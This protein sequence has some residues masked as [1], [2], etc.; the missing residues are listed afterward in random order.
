MKVKKLIIS[1]ND[2]QK[3]G[4]SET[5][6][7]IKSGIVGL[8]GKNGSGKTRILNIVE[9]FVGS[10]KDYKKKSN[11]YLYLTGAI[12]DFD[13]AMLWSNLENY[14]IRIDN[15]LLQS[16]DLVMD[17]AGTVTF[18]QLY[19][20]DSLPY[21]NILKTF[22]SKAYSWIIDTFMDGV[23]SFDENEDD[24]SR[25]R[26]KLFKSLLS[27]FIGKDIRLRLSKEKRHYLELDGVEFKFNLLSPGEKILFYYCL[28]LFIIQETKNI[29][30]KDCIIIIDE[31]ELHLH[32]DAQIKL[33][34]ALRDIIGDSGQ[35]WIASHSLSILS[36]LNYDEIFLVKNNKIICP[37]REIPKQS[38]LE[39]MG[40]EGHIDRMSEF[41]QSITS[42][43]YT[44]FMAQCFINP[45]SI[46]LVD[47]NDPQVEVFMNSIKEKNEFHILDFG[48]GKGRVISYLNDN[49]PN[50]KSILYSAMDNDPKSI[51][52]LKKIK[53][54]TKIYNN[55]DNLG[56][57]N[58][59][60]VLMCNVLHE[61]SPLYWYEEFKKIFMSIKD[62]GFLIIIEDEVIPKGERPNEIGFL[63][64]DQNELKVLFNMS[65]L[66]SL[67]KPKNE[68]WK[69][70]ILC[71]LI[72]KKNIDAITPNSIIMAIELLKDRAYKHV[73]NLKKMPENKGRDINFSRKYA[74]YSQMFINST[75]ALEILREKLQ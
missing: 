56:L 51:L 64:L 20:S 25:K 9:N 19:P 61:I 39:L 8:F 34:N 11:D 35:C 66:P 50:G 74:F 15:S 26:M 67:I 3:T 29:N 52:E 14:I 62:D 72:N 38:L 71:A 12:P 44:N 63:V 32:P 13:S 36:I 31:P 68:K 30:L 41:V 33:I 21:T 49:Y 24:K 55:S 40:V 7:N 69:D 58:F 17:N 73:V 1:K 47:V 48:A 5:E 75:Y 45:D 43:A 70:R 54:I 57:N 37:S 4:I 42:W 46:P 18:D 28:I 22:Q 10:F 65:D 6:I 53:N 2:F 60:Y 16:L 23:Q 27:T 59:D